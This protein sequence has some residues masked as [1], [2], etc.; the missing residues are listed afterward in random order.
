MAL[1]S[2]STLES[3]PAGTLN[4]G[5]IINDNW[6]KINKL[7]DPALSSGD[8]LYGL[9]AQAIEGQ[10]GGLTTYIQ[11][12]L[13]MSPVGYWP[14][15]ETSGTSFDDAST[16]T[17]TGTSSGTVTVNSAQSIIGSADKAPLFVA[18]SSGYI[19]A[20]GAAPLA[21]TPNTTAW[22]VSAW[23]KVSINADY[24]IVSKTGSGTNRNF[25]LSVSATANQ[26]DV[27]LGSTVQAAPA[28]SLN[29][30]LWH[31]VAVTSSGSV[32]RV[33]YDGREVHSFTPG[34]TAENSVDW[35]IGA[36]RTGGENV[37]TGATA[38]LNGNIAHVALFA[39][40][41]T[42]AQVGRLSNGRETQ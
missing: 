15:N 32:A 10:G 17:A 8:P 24:T 40:Q 42:A 12:V 33:Y 26:L 3:H 5:G 20:S 7:F 34:S 22:S 36:R 38:Y 27:H 41:L 6:G 2:P 11:R 28:P 4:I 13:G 30:N 39:A 19:A 14:L 35:L 1:L 25:Q 18:A 23:V 37:N 31:H 21:F 16:G 29:N 9:I